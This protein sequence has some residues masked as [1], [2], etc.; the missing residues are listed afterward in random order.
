MSLFRFVRLLCYMYGATVERDECI[1][2]V[3]EQRFLRRVARS[4][5]LSTMNVLAF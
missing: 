1:I 3:I 2:A 4:L 5:L